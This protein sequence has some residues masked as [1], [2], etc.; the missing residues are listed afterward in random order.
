MSI[1]KGQFIGNITEY[2]NHHLAGGTYRPSPAVIRQL[3]VDPVAGQHAMERERTDQA[4]AANRHGK[5]LLR[6]RLGNS[7]YSP[8]QG[9]AERLRR[10]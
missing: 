1:H 9:A 2:I 3:A 7:K 8:H 5:K 10:A 4:M 6:R